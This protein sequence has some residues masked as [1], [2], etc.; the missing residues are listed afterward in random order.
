MKIKLRG[1]YSYFNFNQEQE[2]NSYH[3]ENHIA[4]H[5]HDS[6]IESELYHILNEYIPFAISSGK[7]SEASLQSPFINGEARTKVIKQLALTILRSKNFD[8]HHQ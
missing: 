2:I 4:H 8:I 3:M 6:K 1:T 5:C 7:G